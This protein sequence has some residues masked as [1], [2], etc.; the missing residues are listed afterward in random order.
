[1]KSKKKRVVYKTNSEKT[2]KR[3]QKMFFYQWKG[4]DLYS[5]RGKITRKRES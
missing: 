3:G 4:V 5:Q 1:M 2:S